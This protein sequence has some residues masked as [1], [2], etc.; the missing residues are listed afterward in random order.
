MRRALW[1]QCPNSQRKNLSPNGLVIPSRIQTYLVPVEYKNSF[2]HGWKA[3]NAGLDLTLPMQF[4]IK[5]ER[6]KYYLNGRQHDLSGPQL[7][8]DCVF[9]LNTLQE[10]PRQLVKHFSI[11]QHGTLHGFVGYF[12]LTL[13]PGITLSNYPRYEGCHWENWNWPISPHLSVK[14]RDVIEVRLEA[15]YQPGSEKFVKGSKDTTS[16]WEPQ[17]DWQVRWTHVP[18]AQT[19]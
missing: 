2:R 1:K 6:V 7:I 19:A 12:D 10:R 13:A 15:M 5:E 11:A 17:Y 3:D 4:L 9:T 18:A 14:P 8:E 16:G